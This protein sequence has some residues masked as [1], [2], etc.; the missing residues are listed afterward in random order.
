MAMSIPGRLR[1]MG[2]WLPPR[3]RSQGSC[4]LQPPI[5]APTPRSQE[6]NLWFSG[7]FTTFSL[8]LFLSLPFSLWTS[9][10]SFLLLLCSGTVNL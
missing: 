8:S 2:L 7:P 5:V 1:I 4:Q 10:L 6:P 9:S 3:H